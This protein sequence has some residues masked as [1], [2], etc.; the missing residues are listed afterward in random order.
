MAVIDGGGTVPPS[1]GV[2]AD[3]VRRGHH[4]RVLGDG[5]VE[6]SAAAAG[7]EFTPWTHAPHSDT[8]ADHTAAIAAAEHGSPLEKRQ[9]RWH[10][11]AAR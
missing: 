10:T 9:P 5:T 3:L 11:A 8:L 6:S 4:V 1:L 2:A 7:C